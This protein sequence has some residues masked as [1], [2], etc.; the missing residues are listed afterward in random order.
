[1]E[2]LMERRFSAKDEAFYRKLILPEEDRA[3]YTALQPRR[4]Y[5]WFRSTNVVCLEHYRRPIEAKSA[6][7]LKVS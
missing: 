7:R 5:R 4:S 6:P 3:E 2:S 1:M